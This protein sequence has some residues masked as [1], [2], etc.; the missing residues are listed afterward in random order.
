MLNKL[1]AFALLMM[2]SAIVYSAGVMDREYQAVDAAGKYLIEK[3]PGCTKYRVINLTK[4]YTVG[5]AITKYNEY[6]TVTVTGYSFRVACVEYGVNPP[7]GK[8]WDVT[9]DAPIT[10]ADGTKLEAS[11]IALYE[12]WVDDVLHGVTKG[13]LYRIEFDDNLEHK[14]KL[15]TVDIYN[16]KSVFS[17]EIAL[18]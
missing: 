6:Q 9:F 14:V 12:I 4:G 16:L 11:E 1:F 2:A 15:K 7:I 3:I 10:R 5:T 17:T 13:S 8:V 18:R